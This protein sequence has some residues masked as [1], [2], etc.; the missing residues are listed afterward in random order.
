[1]HV[2][3]GKAK[4]RVIKGYDEKDD[5]DNFFLDEQERSKIKKASGTKIEEAVVETRAWDANGKV[6][7]SPKPHRV[8]RIDGGRWFVYDIGLRF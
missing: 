8:R 7:G 1:M 6:V 3:F 4:I 5:Y 2:T